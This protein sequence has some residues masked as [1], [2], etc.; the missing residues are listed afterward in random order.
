MNPLRIF[1]LF[2]IF[3]IHAIKVNSQI[4]TGDNFEGR[5]RS[6]PEW[7]FGIGWNAVDDNS[8][9]FKKLFDIRK[10]WNL[11]PYP[12][13]LSVDRTNGGLLSY[14]AVFNFNQY[15]AGKLVYGK[16]LGGTFLFFSL[17]LN[18]KYH[19]GPLLRLPDRFD[20]YFPVGGG[21]T[22]RFAPPYISTGTFNVGLG[23]NYWILDWLGINLQ[24]MAKF[25]M[26][27]PI[28]KTASNYL[29]H[30][31]GLVFN[32]TAF[33]KTKHPFVKPRYPWVHRKKIGRERT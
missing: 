27:S 26:R 18:V 32:L 1:L 24:S 33:K 5:G 29:Q 30:S 2:F 22:L 31:A 16:P 23:G 28:F 7:I 19:F 9:A 4:I 14:G 8:N 3:C 11:R 6:R 20:I 10:S 21:Y 17:D 12:S 15:R 13:Q 25:G